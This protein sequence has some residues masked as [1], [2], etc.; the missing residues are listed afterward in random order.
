MSL[1]LTKIVLKCVLTFSKNSKSHPQ[2]QSN[3][4]Y[5][6]SVNSGPNIIKHLHWCNLLQNAGFLH[7]LVKYS[8]GQYYKTFTPTFWSKLHQKLVLRGF[9]PKLKFTP[10]SVFF[11][12]ASH[13]GVLGGIGRCWEM[14][15]NI[16]RR[17]EMLGG[18]GWCWEV[19]GS[20]G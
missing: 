16:G 7:I 10:K 13:V 4:S 17:W 12:C 2:T 20:D 18:V 5:F 6:N 3:K 15:G 14:L 9:I 19:L 1:L 11:V 8:L